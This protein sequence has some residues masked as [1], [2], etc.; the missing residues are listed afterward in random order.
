MTHHEKTPTNPLTAVEEA[1]E[2]TLK[3]ERS[4][5]RW[6]V[7]SRATTV[8]AVLAF[9]LFG[10]YLAFTNIQLRVEL[11]EASDRLAER[12][13][14]ASAL[15]QQLLA[16]GERPV[17]EPTEPDTQGTA[18]PQGMPGDRG[19]PGI[20]GVPSIPGEPG[21]NGLNG[22]NGLD[23][24]KGLDGQDGQQGE[25]GPQGERGL[26]GLQGPQGEQ[27]PAGEP[28]PTGYAMI[29]L[30]GSFSPTVSVDDSVFREVKVC[31]PQ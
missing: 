18:G 23:G 3:K 17:V 12:H 13:A 31:V 28:C 10:V 4:A 19:V 29:S 25:R 7:I 16:A 6:V 1:Q 11:S 24:Q 21:Q 20:Q 5:R 15:Y 9:L 14:E 30:W 2:V 8:T 26:Q 22:Q 27:G